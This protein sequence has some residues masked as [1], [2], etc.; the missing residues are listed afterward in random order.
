MEVADIRSQLST[1]VACLSCKP[2]L[3]LDGTHLTSKYGGILLAATATNAQGQ[4]FPFAFAIVS[5]ENDDNW[6]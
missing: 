2:L 4:L 1:V 6:F 5:V 3:E